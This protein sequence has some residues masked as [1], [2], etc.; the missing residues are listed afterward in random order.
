MNAKFEKF[1]IVY[2]GDYING[3]FKPVERADNS[4]KDISPS[5]LS[6]LVM[7]VPFRYDHIE[8]GV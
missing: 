2:Q 7:T 6:D 1:P 3:R 8:E 4:F 5:D